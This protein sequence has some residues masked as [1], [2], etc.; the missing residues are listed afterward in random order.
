MNLYFRH[1]TTL[2]ILLLIACFHVVTAP[3]VHGKASMTVVLDQQRLL[4]TAVMPAHDLVGFEHLA[5]TDEDKTTVKQ[6]V[7]KLEQTQQWIHLKAGQCELK[8]VH[9]FDPLSVE[10]E[11]TGDDHHSET[12]NHHH[13]SDH[14]D[15]EV[16]AEM[17][18]QKPDLINALEVKLHHL[19]QQIQNIEVQWVVNGKQGLST[20]NQQNHVVKFQ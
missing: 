6:A 12:E 16:S 10:G 20:L 19:F 15:F 17:R 1:K 8:S 2:I 5:E 7:S 13:H 9:V 18:C 3:H 11:H 4:L 14:G